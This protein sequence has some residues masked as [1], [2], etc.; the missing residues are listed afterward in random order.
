MTLPVETITETITLTPSAANAA[1]EVMVSKKLNGYALRLFIMGS[2]CSGY[3]YGLGL[4]NNIQSDDTVF[5]TDGIKL[6]VANE[7]LDYLQGTTVDY[8]ENENAS[9][10]KI[11]NPHPLVSCGCCQGSASTNGETSG[12]CAG[13]G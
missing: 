13:C 2:G 3:Q 6:I 12:G 8:I 11:S 7:L 1:R 4:D 10:F 9:G 5:E